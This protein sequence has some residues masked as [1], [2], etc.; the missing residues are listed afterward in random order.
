MKIVINKCYGGFGLSAKAVKRMAELQG[1][2][3]YFFTYDF[4]T[5]QHYPIEFEKIS[6]SEILKTWSTYDIPDLTG[7]PS[8]EDWHS[9]IDDYRKECNRIW[10]LHSIENGREIDRTDPHL[11]QAVE[12]LGEEANGDFAKLKVVEIP[13]GLDYEIDEYDGMESIHEKHQIWY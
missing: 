4:K 6:T 1:R 12:E 5:S 3:C 9:R 2:P 8:Q 13:D 10:N 11:I 7:L